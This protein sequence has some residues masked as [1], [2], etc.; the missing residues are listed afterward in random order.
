MCPCEDTLLLQY[1]RF[2][3]HFLN[4]NVSIAPPSPPQLYFFVRRFLSTTGK[5]VAC[6]W[7]HLTMS[8]HTHTHTHTHPH[9]HPHPHTC[10]REFKRSERDDRIVDRSSICGEQRRVRRR[11]CQSFCCRN[12]DETERGFPHL[13]GFPLV[14]QGFPLP[15]GTRERQRRGWQI[16]GIL[17]LQDISRF[18]AVRG[19]ALYYRR[20]PPFHDFFFFFVESWEALYFSRT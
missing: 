12:F 14:W 18:R 15:G 10:T 2:R 1:S 19:A 11:C 6:N 20:Y 16:R 13:A 7:H 17:E 8:P 3:R 5:A 4:G 9:T